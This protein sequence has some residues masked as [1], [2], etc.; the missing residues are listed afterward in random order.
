[1]FEEKQMF[2][3]NPAGAEPAACRAQGLLQHPGGTGVRH[4]YQDQPQERDRAGR[5]RNHTVQ[6]LAAITDTA[7]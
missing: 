1:M 3:G 7:S 5:R 4:R 2:E 6:S